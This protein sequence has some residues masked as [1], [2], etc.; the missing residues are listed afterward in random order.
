MVMIP[1][2]S[3]S[4]PCLR[5]RQAGIQ[6][7]RW[8]CF[9]LG[10]SCFSSHWDGGPMAYCFWSVATDLAVVPI[11]AGSYLS[12]K[13]GDVYVVQS[14]VVMML[15][16]WLVYS[17]KIDIRSW[18]R[19]LIVSLSGIVLGLAQW[20]RTQSGS[21]VLVFFALFIMFQLSSA[22][23]SDSAVAH[24]A[25]W[26]EP[27]VALCTVSITRARQVPRRAFTWLSR[28]FESSPILACGLPGSELPDE[29]VCA[30]MRDSV[31]VEYVQAS[32]RPR[33][34]AEKN[35]R[36]FCGREWRRSRT[37]TTNSSFIP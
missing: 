3:I 2:S 16:P 9:F 19:F 36:R 27:A 37:G 11:A 1:A 33:S 18:L 24:A 32:I 31:G 21:P 22:N 35:T 14:S 29:S 34:M 15:I 12:F 26:Y 6:T 7:D 20:V 25:D 23:D 30:S 5:G 4:F 17:L 10:Y 13:M 8:M 28:F